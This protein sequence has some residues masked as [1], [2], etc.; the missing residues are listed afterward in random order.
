[1]LRKL[2]LVLL[3]TFVLGLVSCAGDDTS[4]QEN[5][6]EY[7]KSYNIVDVISGEET[8]NG[9]EMVI[10]TDG[11]GGTIQAEVTVKDGVITV[12][13]ITEQSE[14]AG[15]GQA[16][17]NDSGIIQALIDDSDDLDNFDVNTYLDAQASATITAEA[18]LDIAKTAIEHYEEDYQ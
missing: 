6:I 2:S 18:L 3:F 1:M 11:F 5:G 14:S 17:I 9:V 13:T 4:T 10:E 16:V 15:W 7:P 8:D 12:F